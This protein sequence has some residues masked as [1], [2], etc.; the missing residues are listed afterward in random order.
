MSGELFERLIRDIPL[1]NDAALARFLAVRPPVISKIRHGRARI[2]A[3]LL[4]HIYDRLRANDAPW[5]FDRLRAAVPPLL[6]DSYQASI[7]NQ[8]PA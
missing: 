4:V 3:D 5:E 8:E 7:P 2:T 6:I 1:K